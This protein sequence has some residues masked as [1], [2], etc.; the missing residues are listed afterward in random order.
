[1]GGYVSNPLS[2]KKY[3]KIPPRRLISG[4]LHINVISHDDNDDKKD[5]YQWYRDEIVAGDQETDWHSAQPWYGQAAGVFDDEG[6]ANKFL[7]FGDYDCLL[8]WVAGGMTLQT[9][10]FT[11][12]AL[13]TFTLASN[14]YPDTTAGVW[15]TGIDD[16]CQNFVKYDL[17]SRINNGYGHAALMG[18]ELYLG[19]VPVTKN[20]FRSDAAGVS[21][22]DSTAT[23][24]D[25]DTTGGEAP[26]THGGNFQKH[27]MSCG[28]HSTSANTGDGDID[29]STANKNTFFPPVQDVEV[30]GIHRLN[31]ASQTNG[32]TLVYSIAASE[33]G[34]HLTDFWNLVIDIKIRGYDDGWSSGSPSDA[35]REWFKSR[36]NVFFQPFGETGNLD[37]SDTEHTS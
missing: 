37:I 36:V 3:I 10:L 35:D 9:P 13:S 2:I 11:G 32:S 27:I 18:D 20:E 19:T 30:Y 24:P 23:P 5:A 21:G 25:Y 26:N 22:H 16:Y 34:Y 15:Y 28:S 33:G 1:M 14:S 12:S 17:I 31:I 4:F 7:S 29:L 6:R 8:F